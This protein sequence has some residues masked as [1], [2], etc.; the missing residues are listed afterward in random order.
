M[1]LVDFKDHV[2]EFLEKYNDPGNEHDISGEL[3]EEHRVQKIITG[4]P[5]FGQ[6]STNFPCVFVKIAEYDQEITSM[7]NSNHRHVAFS[8]DIFP[9]TQYGA[10]VDGGGNVAAEEECLTLTENILN[11]LRAKYDLSMSS[12]DVTLVT[13]L[14]TSFDE[15]VGE[16]TYVKMNKISAVGNQYIT[17]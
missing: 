10:G 7:G 15:A 1:K 9:C 17:S 11:L 14:R 4:P 6:I 8:V 16:S 2:K 12:D 5:S 3:K 13:E